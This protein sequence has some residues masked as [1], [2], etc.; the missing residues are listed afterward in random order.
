METGGRL[1]HVVDLDGAFTGS[2]EN[3]DA[4]R[5]I[6]EVDGLSVQLGGGIAMNLH[7]KCP[8][9]GALPCDHWDPRCTDP[10]W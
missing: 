5:E 10:Q 6:L 7:C 3:L 4:V 1:T 9:D 8:G 2:S